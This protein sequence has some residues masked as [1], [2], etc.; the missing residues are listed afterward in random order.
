MHYKLRFWDHQFK[1]LIQF[2]LV[3]GGEF[4]ITSVGSKD[5]SVTISRLDYKGENTT[6]FLKYQTTLGDR[7]VVTYVVN[8]VSGGVEIKLESIQDGN[9]I[10]QTTDDPTCERIMRDCYF[11]LTKNLSTFWFQ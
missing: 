4:N 11:A 1:S 7:S 3:E 5:S 8:N 10:Y 9:G 6:D 2:H